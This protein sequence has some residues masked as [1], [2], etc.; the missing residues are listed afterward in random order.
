MHPPEDVRRDIVELIELAPHGLGSLR[1]SR[2]LGISPSTLAGWRLRY[3]TGDFVRV[4]VSKRDRDGLWSV[5]ESDLDH[6]VALRLVLGMLRL[7]RLQQLVDQLPEG[8][9]PAASE[10]SIR[11]AIAFVQTHLKNADPSIPATVWIWGRLG[12]AEADL[13]R[14]LAGEGRDPERSPAQLGLA[15]DDAG[16]VPLFDAAGLVAAPSSLSV[17]ELLQDADATARD[18]LFAPEGHQ[19]AAMVRSW[20][21]LVSAAA[22]LLQ[23]LPG[24]A[25]AGSELTRELLE[26]AQSLTAAAEDLAWPAAG[27]GGDLRLDQITSNLDTAARLIRDHP[28]DVHDPAHGPGPAALADVDAARAAALHALHMATHAVGLA[29]REHVQETR[30]TRSDRPSVSIRGAGWRQRAEA[31]EQLLWPELPGFPRALAGLRTARPEESSEDRV[32]AALEAWRVQA[33]RVLANNPNPASLA[34]IAKVQGMTAAPTA[35]LTSAG[36]LAEEIVPDRVAQACQETGTAWSTLA[37]RWRDLAET[38]TSDPALAQAAAELRAACRELTHNP[39]GPAAAEQ[40]TARPGIATATR[41]LLDAAR[42][43]PDLAARFLQATADPN[44]RG[45]AAAMLRRTEEEAERSGLTTYDR[46][47]LQARG[48]IAPT[49][50]VRQ[51]LVHATATTAHHA[52]ALGQA[53]QIRPGTPSPQ[54]GLQ[55]ANLGLSDRH[56]APLAHQENEDLENVAALAAELAQAQQLCEELEEKLAAVKA[57]GAGLADRWSRSTWRTTK[58]DAAIDAFAESTASLGD[59]EALSSA[60]LQLEA[61]VDEARRLGEVINDAGA[62]GTFP[63]SS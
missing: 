43:G 22:G 58:L 44:L 48:L 15:D 29:L 51:A 33:N 45:P 16:D 60:I 30:I 37:D 13:A 9:D 62:Y 25:G 36:V 6:T 34:L 49:A 38:H 54:A 18:L 12:E 63:G 26:R 35:I 50:L 10:P 56:P 55:R 2:V 1:L 61:A 41:A 47:S 24:P 23:T 40:I 5:L 32:P 57:L 59:V 19:A 4:P 46:P 28:L 53:A 7:A 11:D 20:T 39:D 27:G 31:L 8:T 21:P 52:E 14:L 17:G 3:G 42:R